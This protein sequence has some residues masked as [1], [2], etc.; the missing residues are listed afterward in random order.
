MNVESV[1]ERLAAD[2]AGL[3]ADLQKDPRTRIQPYTVKELAKL[4]RRHPNYISDKCRTG[5]IS[6]LGG[7]P[8]MIPPG[9]AS[10]FLQIV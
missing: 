1:L 8:Y 6:T 9:A 2:V 7:K 3:R 4:A 5:Q 10:R